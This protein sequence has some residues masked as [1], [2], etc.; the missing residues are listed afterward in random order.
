LNQLRPTR[1]ISH[2]ILNKNLRDSLLLGT[3][4]LRSRSVQ[5]L[6]EICRLGTHSRVNV[7]FTALDV[8]MQIIP[9]H[10]YQV[11]SVVARL[12]IGMT[13]KQYCKNKTI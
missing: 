13:W 8:I 6:E 1:L 9:K 2:F 5:H 11:D 10:V 3:F 12:P 4:G 7:N